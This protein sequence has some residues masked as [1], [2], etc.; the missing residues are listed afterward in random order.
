MLSGTLIRKIDNPDKK[1]IILFEYLA[2]EY[3]LTV[4]ALFIKRTT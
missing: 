1:M 4:D 2:F 3:D